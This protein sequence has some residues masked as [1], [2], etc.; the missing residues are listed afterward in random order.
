MSNIQKQEYQDFIVEIKDKIYQSQYQ[1]MRAVNKE[2]INLYTEIGKAIVEK[3]ETL[4]WG[5]SIVENLA[6]DL[7]NEFPGIKGFSAQNLWYIR[8]FYLHYKDNKKLQPMVGEISWSKNL[9]II[10]K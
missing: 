1:A 2:L 5:K 10:S 3:Q 6:K 4:G 8:Q 7:E 9:V